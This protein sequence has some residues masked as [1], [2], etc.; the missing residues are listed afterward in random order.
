M[1]APV[2]MNICPTEELLAAFI[3][4]RLAKPDRQRVMEHMADCAECRDIMM[5]ANEF[6][7]IEGKGGGKVSRFSPGVIF[8]GGAMLAAAAVLLIVFSAPLMNLIRGRSTEMAELIELS[9]TRKERPLDGR[10]SGGFAYGE[11]PARNRGP[12][13]D[14]SDNLR[15]QAIAARL[16][17]KPQTV[18]GLHELGVARMYEG[19]R[20]KGLESLISAIKLET[21]E[22]NLERAIEKSNDVALLTDLAAALLHPISDDYTKLRPAARKAAERAWQLKKSPETAWNRALSLESPDGSQTAQSRAAWTE[23]QKLDPG[24]PWAREAMDNATERDDF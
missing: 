11:K 3:D 10:L 17:G 6:A 20:A 16:E 4:G 9:E 21:G 13:E 22:T 14:A 24:S 12:V 19:E 5:S 1:T 7:V 8:T 18:R 23:Y 2:A 15:F